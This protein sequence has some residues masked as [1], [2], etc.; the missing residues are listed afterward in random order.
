MSVA[1]MSVAVMSGAIVFAGPTSAVHAGSSMQSAPATVPDPDTPAVTA[2]EFLPEDRDLTDCV[3]VLEKPGCGSEERGGTMLNI[4]FVLV[5]GG[6]S[7]IFWRIIVGVRRNRSALGEPE[8]TGPEP[9]EPE[10]TGPEPTAQ[11]PT[12]Q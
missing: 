6:M 4:V 12:G 1:V 7:F 9:T 11:D 2:N 10:P 8:P 3:G 5:I